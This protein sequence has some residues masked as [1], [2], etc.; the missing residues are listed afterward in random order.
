MPEVGQGGH[1]V[2]VLVPPCEDATGLAAFG[3]E[4][5]RGDIRDPEAAQRLVS[6]QG[7]AVLIHTAGVIHPRWRTRDF[8]EVNVDGTRNIVRAAADAR[9]RRVIVMS[10]NSPVGASKSPVELFD[11]ASS[12][13][14]YM[15]YGKSKFAMEEWLR[16]RIL[17]SKPPEI[18]IIRAP[19]FYGPG[20]P[21][22][23]TSF[24][25]LIKEGKFPMTNRG[26]SRRSMVY[27]DSLAY[28]LLLAAV[29]PRAAGESYWL[30]DERPYPMHEIVTTV[31]TVLRDDFGMKISARTLRV[32][33]IVSDIAR[34]TDRLL[35]GAGCYCRNIHVLSEMNLTIACVID[36]AQRDI[37]YRPIVDLR[38][39]LRR[40]VEWCLAHGIAI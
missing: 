17:A 40:S 1:N 18:T 13:H 5:I 16:T 35:Q 23:Q 8:W 12:C 28:G 6:E 21:E 15:G 9:V 27:I 39:G 24:F 31:R 26:E 7:D 29:S 14:P 34:V 30:A 10:S 38:E 4:V 33:G 36:K 20:Q 2:R 19:W 25:T 3:A 22:R 11:E 32:P 37:A